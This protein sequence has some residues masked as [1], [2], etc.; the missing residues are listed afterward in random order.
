[1]KSDFEVGGAKSDGSGK[2]ARE[3]GC[4]GPIT[5][6]R[7]KSLKAESTLK[8]ERSPTLPPFDLSVILPLHG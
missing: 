1:M 7:G 3:G 8:N 6:Y 4:I 5:F 2:V